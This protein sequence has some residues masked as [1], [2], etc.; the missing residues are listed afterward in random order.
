MVTLIHGNWH[1][2]VYTYICRFPIIIVVIITWPREKPSEK[3]NSD[4]TVIWVSDW[5]KWV[6]FMQN[7]EHDVTV[8]YMMSQLAS[9]ERQV[10]V[11]CCLL[12]AVFN[13]C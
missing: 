11:F 13:N 5:F 2:L 9:N 12:F 7:L 3:K 6:N 10:S 4:I 8:S 1:Y